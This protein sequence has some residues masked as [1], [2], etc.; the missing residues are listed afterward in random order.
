MFVQTTLLAK[1]NCR[2]ENI[3][4]LKTLYTTVHYRVPTR[5]LGKVK[6]VETSNINGY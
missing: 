5:V 4:E 2:Y 1:I 3:L 6:P